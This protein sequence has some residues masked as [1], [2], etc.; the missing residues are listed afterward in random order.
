LSSE[1]ATQ[2]AVFA[3]DLHCEGDQQ[4]QAYTKMK[5]ALKTIKSFTNKSNV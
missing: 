2:Q 4:M 5:Y 1:I 3:Y